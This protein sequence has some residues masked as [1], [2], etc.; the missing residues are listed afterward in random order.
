MSLSDIVSV[1]I[2]ALTKT[3]TRVGFGTPLIAA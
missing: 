1:S 3:P 2:T